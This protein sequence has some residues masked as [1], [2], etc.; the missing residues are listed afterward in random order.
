MRL[1]SLQ[2]RE[3]ASRSKLQEVLESMFGEELDEEK[4]LQILA[5]VES[6]VA[7]RAEDQSEENLRIGESLVLA[8][9][10]FCM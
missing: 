5:V 6:G 9:L 7:L 4:L 3:F 10:N 2:D 8:R 1:Q